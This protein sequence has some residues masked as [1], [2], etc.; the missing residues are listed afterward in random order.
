MSRSLNPNA[1]PPVKPGL[2]TEAGMPPRRN[3]LAAVAAT[4]IGAL[5]GIVPFAAGLATFL[6]PLLRRKKVRSEGS[7][8]PVRVA[9]LDTIPADGTPVQVPVI[10]DLTDAWNREPNQPVGA[11]YLRREGG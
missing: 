6:D 8:E 2:M 10:A 11:V 1:T 9:S 7:R 4:I 3:V 5:V